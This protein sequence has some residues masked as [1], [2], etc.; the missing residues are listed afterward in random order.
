VLAAEVFDVARLEINALAPRWG[1]QRGGV[2]ATT[3]F[4][5]Q[6]LLRPMQHSAVSGKGLNSPDVVVSGS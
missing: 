3:W 4:E 5:I 6:A 2:L 1:Y